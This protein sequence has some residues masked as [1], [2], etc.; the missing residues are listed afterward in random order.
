MRPSRRS[1]PWLALVA[2]W[3]LWGFTYLAIRVGVETLPPYLM[4]GTRYVIAGLLLGAIQYAMARV[5]PGLPTWKDLGRIAVMGI[6]LL[7]IGNGFLAVAETRVPS[8]ASALLVASTPIWM[9]ILEALRTRTAIGLASLAGLVT[10]TAGIV[11]L[12][13]VEAAHA[14]GP[15][16]ALI[17]IGSFAWALGT[18]YA[19]A[20]E[21]RHPLAAAME[22]VAGG[23][24]SV[25]VGACLGEAA[26]FSFAHVSP[27]SWYGMLWLIVGGAMVGYTAYVYVV[28]NLPAPTVATYA[29]VNPVVAVWLGVLFLGEPVTWKLLLGG[30][31]VI[32]SVAVILLGN[33]RLE[34]ELQ[35]SDAA[36]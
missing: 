9:L 11:V 29:Y 30:A 16:A 1:L 35:G 27:Q 23:L 14:N 15:Y 7:V 24:F 26:H 28:R 3:I 34:D 8:G 12:V 13:G 19:R 25:A 17:L 10:G 20:V 2:V 6:L 18:I 22:M 32:V 33:R 4:I 5:K 21:T 31:A 36:A